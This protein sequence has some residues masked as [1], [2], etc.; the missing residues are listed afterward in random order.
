RL[1]GPSIVARTTTATRAGARVAPRRPASRRAR[2]RRRST[3]WTAW[4]PTPTCWPGSGR[5]RSARGASTSRTS[6]PSTSPCSRRSCGA[7]TRRSR[8]RPRSARG[9][10]E[11]RSRTAPDARPRGA[12]QGGSERGGD[13]ARA[14]PGLGPAQAVEQRVQDAARE[15]PHEVLAA[16]GL[17]EEARAPVH[18]AGVPHGD[19]ASALRVEQV[20]DGDAE[21]VRRLGRVDGADR[22]GA[23]PPREHGRDAVVAHRQRELA[24]RAEDVDA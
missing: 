23:R 2:P 13:R 20:G 7:R 22:R 4:T 11:G 16:V 9:S 24:Q 1:W 19:G 17:D 21:D 14:V 8:A 5:T 12:T 10:R 18:A 15:P 6:T 3:S